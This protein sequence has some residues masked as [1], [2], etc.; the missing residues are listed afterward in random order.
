MF[1]LN[2]HLSQKSPQITDDILR[3]LDN[4]GLNLTLSILNTLTRISHEEN[5][6]RLFSSIRRPSAQT[7]QL[8]KEL[9]LV[10]EEATWRVAAAHE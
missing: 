10:T 1:F 9:L 5:E 7:L 6:N 8:R 3:R 2:R 4:E